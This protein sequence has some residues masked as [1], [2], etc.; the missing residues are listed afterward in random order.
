MNNSRS[1]IYCQSSYGPIFESNADIAVYNNC[2]ANA[3]N[4]TNLGGTYANDTGIPGKHVFTGEYNFTA[5]EIEVF[6]MQP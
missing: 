2:N 4:F 6:A 3:S 1:T 5:N